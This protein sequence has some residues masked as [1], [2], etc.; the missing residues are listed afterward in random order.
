MVNTAHGQNTVN[1]ASL[2]EV[3][4]KR[5]QENVTAQHQLTEELIVKAQ[6][7]MKKLATHKDVQVT[8]IRKQAFDHFLYI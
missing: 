6:L 5:K 7:K 4:N 1:A 8:R 3:E 2:A